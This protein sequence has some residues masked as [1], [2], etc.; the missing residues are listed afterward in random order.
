MHSYLELLSPTLP[1]IETAE[2]KVF[3]EV[4]RLNRKKTFWSRA[5][6]IKVKIGPPKPKF[7]INGQLE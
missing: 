3:E 6:L 5:M 1:K 4:F 7:F 2:S